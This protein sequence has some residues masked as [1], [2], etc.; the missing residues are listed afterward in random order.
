MMR[1]KW[2]DWKPG[3][4]IIESP[5]HVLPTKPTKPGSVG[6]EGTARRSF[7]IAHDLFR[8]RVDRVLAT[9]NELVDPTGLDDWLRAEQPDL[10]ARGRQLV[11]AIDLAMTISDVTELEKAL[12]RLKGFHR[13]CCRLFERHLQNVAQGLLESPRSR[14]RDETGTGASAQEELYWG[15]EQAEPQRCRTGQVTCT[16]KSAT[17]AEGADG[18]E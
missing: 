17:G 4:E 18:D 3:D 5:P 14:D 13:E 10:L 9:I 7:A 2:L 15:S 11:A 16:A 8:S 1:S 12:N 6:F